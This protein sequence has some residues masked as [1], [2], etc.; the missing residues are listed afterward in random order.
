M[1][2]KV[3]VREAEGWRSPEGAVRSL[4]QHCIIIL[5]IIIII[6]IIISC[7]KCVISVKLEA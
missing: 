7:D 2:L 4:Q 3:V 1:R 6:I 5:I